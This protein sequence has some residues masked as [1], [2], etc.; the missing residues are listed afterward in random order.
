MSQA[1]NGWRVINGGHVAAPDCPVRHYAGQSKD[2]TTNSMVGVADKERDC[3]LTEG[4]Q[5]LSN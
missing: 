4:N 3:A 2:A 5:S 1:A